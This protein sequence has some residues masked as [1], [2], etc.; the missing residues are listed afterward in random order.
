MMKE[1]TFEDGPMGMGLDAIEEGQDGAKV[2]M[3][4]EGSQAEKI[5]VQEGDLVKFIA[6]ENVTETNIESMMKMLQES[7]RP[8]KIVFATKQLDTDN[9]IFFKAGDLGLEFSEAADMH[10]TVVKAINKGGQ[11]WTSGIIEPGNVLIAVNNRDVQAFPYNKVMDIVKTS[12]RPGHFSFRP[13]EGQLKA[14]EEKRKQAQALASRK[15]DSASEKAAA[16]KAKEEFEKE[17]KKSKER[18]E[19]EQKRR[20]KEAEASKLSRAEREQQ[21]QEK[22]LAAK[23]K[24]NDQRHREV[25]AEIKKKQE[26][27]LMH[28]FLPGKKVEVWWEKMHNTFPGKVKEVD[29]DGDIT[30]LYDHGPTK[31]YTKSYLEK[32]IKLGIEHEHM[33]RE[34]RRKKKELR[35][36]AADAGF[37]L[38]QDCELYDTKEHH[39]VTCKVLRVGDDAEGV[40]VQSLDGSLTEFTLDEMINR[41]DKAIEFLAEEKRTKKRCKKLGYNIGKKVSIWLEKHERAFIATIRQYYHANVK[42]LFDDGDITS[43]PVETLHQKILKATEMAR[44]E[45]D[46]SARAEKHGVIAGAKVSV[47]W[48]SANKI[49][50][51]DV[52]GFAGFKIHVQYQDGDDRLYELDELLDRMEAAIVESERIRKE[53]IQKEKLRKAKLLARKKELERK[54]RIA[55]IEAAKRRKEEMRLAKVREEEEQERLLLESIAAEEAERARQAEL[56]RLQREAEEAEIRRFKQLRGERIQYNDA[57]STVREISIQTDALPP[58]GPIRTPPRILKVDDVIGWHRDGLELI[59]RGYRSKVGLNK[60]GTN[61]P[62]FA[63]ISRHR[64]TVG[65]EEYLQLTG[66]FQLRSGRNRRVDGRGKKLVATNQAWYKLWSEI[67]LA[68]PDIIEANLREIGQI[69]SELGLGNAVFASSAMAQIEY[70]SEDPRIP[71]KLSFDGALPI[72]MEEAVSIFNRSAGTENAFRH[73]DIDGF[74]KALV[75]L[76]Y[77]GVRRACPTSDFVRSCYKS[78]SSRAAFFNSVTPPGRQMRNKIAFRH[79]TEYQ[80]IWSWVTESRVQAQGRSFVRNYLGDE[81][82]AAACVIQAVARGMIYRSLRR[83]KYDA[84][85]HIQTMVRGKLQRLRFSRALAIRRA[86]AEMV[87]VNRIAS[88]RPSQ[89]LM[90]VM[91]RIGVG[92]LNQLKR[93]LMAANRGFVYGEMTDSTI[94]WTTDQLDNDYIGDNLRGS[95]IDMTNLFLSDNRGSPMPGEQSPT[96]PSPLPSPSADATGL[97]ADF[98]ANM[99]E[100]C[101]DDTEGDGNWLDSMGIHG[102]PEENKDMLA[103]MKEHAKEVHDKLEQ[104]HQ[105][106]NFEIQGFAQEAQGNLPAITWTDLEKINKTEKERRRRKVRQ[107]FVRE[108]DG[109][110]RGDQLFTPNVYPATPPQVSWQQIQNV[111]LVGVDS[112]Y[113]NAYIAK[114]NKIP[115]QRTQSS[116]RSATKTSQSRSPVASKR[117]LRVSP[118][119]RGGGQKQPSKPKGG[120]SSGGSGR[121]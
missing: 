52:V 27:A 108:G 29:E 118:K 88:L 120:R 1:V 22:K 119:K 86:V 96:F 17:Q 113:T 2:K 110:G 72:L 68:Y 5:G 67:P 71:P 83:Q 38:N 121:Y 41:R 95:K 65:K 92:S 66:D 74:H 61:N 24:W 80:C 46:L 114:N 116:F 91:E 81:K 62:T 100:D 78:V 48:P 54:K 14:Q 103:H 12:R 23:K 79:F 64:H 49:F 51:G 102:Q 55:K 20:N 18:S 3:V 85:L 94:K 36:E 57:K 16:D 63:E 87:A 89:C 90:A 76:S 13:T 69:S 56:E 19:R 30:I 9:D 115:R 10:Q 15:V 7:P 32:L 60:I 58:P 98:G 59:H 93:K 28:G 6:G 50:N 53:N 112:A 84:A 75:A 21:K 33:E 8:L 109:L 42:V 26:T 43:Y 117:K 106:H 105:N 40:V 4:S 70:A 82:D 47:W 111:D 37:K 97:G 104:K 73:L 34:R 35:S 39:V 99:L 44:I 25:I 77:K 107:P 11:A 31:G 45:G 101:G